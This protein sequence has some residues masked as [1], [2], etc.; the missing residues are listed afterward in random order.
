MK[1]LILPIAI[2]VM[3]SACKKPAMEAT[4]NTTI[5]IPWTDTSSRHP[6]ST[7]FGALLTKYH[8]LGLPGISLLVNDEMGTWLGATGKADIENNIPFQVGQVGKVASIT[9]LFMGALVFKLI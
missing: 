9:K 8:K 7:A 3:L 1:N 2:L 5:P 4:D 6:K